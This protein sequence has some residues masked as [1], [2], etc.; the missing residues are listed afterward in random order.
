VATF[1]I[2]GTL[3]VFLAVILYQFRIRLLGDDMGTNWMLI[4]IGTVLV[5]PHLGMAL[6]ASG[7]WQPKENR[8]EGRKFVA[9]QLRASSAVLGAPS[10]RWRV[11][12]EAWRRRYQPTVAR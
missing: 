4:M 6:G 12:G 10:R 9:H 11:P 2:V 5:N 1:M 8:H 7:W 3:C